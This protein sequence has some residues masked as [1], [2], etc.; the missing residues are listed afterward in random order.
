MALWSNIDNEA[1]K[2]KYLTAAEKEDTL[3]VDVAEAQDAGNRAKGIATPGWVKYETYT[4]SNG[5]TRN[6]SEV[7]VALKTITGDNDTIDPDPVITIA[8]QPANE[9]VTDGDPAEFTVVA[10]TDRDPVELS[11]QWQ[12]STDGI[13]FADITG[14]TADTLTVEDGDAEY[15]DGNEFR[16]VVSATGADDVTSDAA[17]LTITA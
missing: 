3:G 13:T 14:A 5:V 16:V 17:T 10:G 7:L 1:S 11:Y 12:V 15:V 8:T 2:P 9:S 6:K 4:D